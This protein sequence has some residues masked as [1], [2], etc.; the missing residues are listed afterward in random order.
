M[1]RVRDTG[2]A[3]LACLAGSGLAVVLLTRP[4]T[5][6]SGVGPVVVGTGCRL[7]EVGDRPPCDCAS[8]PAPL[9]WALGLPIRLEGAEPA[10][11]RLLP[12]VG[13]AL[14]GR[15]LDLRDGPGGVDRLRALE[16][17]RGIGPKTL[18]RLR[19]RLHVS[20]PDPACEA[21]GSL[22]VGP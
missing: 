11:L 18:E 6:P 4:P 12:G 21:S 13:P 8:V 7:A 2:R 15:I 19:G 5:A 9:R 10:D 20:G 17:A 14:A 3:R 16:R 1:R 22:R